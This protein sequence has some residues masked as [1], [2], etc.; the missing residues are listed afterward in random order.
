MQ[1]RIRVDFNTMTM[2]DNGRVYIKE[3]GD[4]LEKPNAITETEL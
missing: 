1:P 3:A 4:A 2:L